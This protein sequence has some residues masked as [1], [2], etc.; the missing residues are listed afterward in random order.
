MYKMKRILKRAIAC[1]LA[2][3][4]LAGEAP[5]QKVLAAEVESQTEQQENVTKE[6]EQQ[7]AVQQAETEQEQQD[8]TDVQL[9]T[10]QPE[11]ANDVQL[12]TEQPE[13]ANDVQ[14]G[15]G[16][17]EETTGIQVEVP[18]LNY[19]Y[20]DKNRVEIGDTQNIVLSVG[21]DTTVIESAKLYVQNK[22]GEQYTLEASEIDGNA[23]LFAENYQDENQTGVYTL[24]SY[25]I[26]VDGIVYTQVL[27]ETGVDVSYGVNCDV[28]STPDAQLVDEDTVE[29]DMD[30]VS[31]DEDGNQTSEDSIA[32]AIENQQ[33]EQSEDGITRS[34]Y[35]SNGN[36]VV[37]LDPGH[38]GSDSGASGNGLREK[39][40]TLKIAQ[41]AKQE[42][43]KYAGVTVYLTRTSDGYV[44]LKDRATYAKSVNADIFV[45]LHINSNKSTSPNGA[46]IY[47][48]NRNY[49]ASFSDIGNGLATKIISKLTALGLNTWRS[50]VGGIIRED[51]CKDPDEEYMYP[52]GSHGDYHSVIRNCKK[53]GIPAILVEHAFISNASDASNYLSSDEKLKKL[54]VADAQGIAE[55]YNLKQG[56]QINGINFQD[57]NN[58]VEISA[59]CSDTKGVQYRYLYYDFA[60]QCWGV[61]SEWTTESKVEWQP[62]AGNYWVQ[63]AAVDSNGNGTTKTVSYTANKNYTGYY[64]NLN[65]MCY[66]MRD[67][68]I[69][70]GVAYDSNAS[71][72]K[73]KWQAYNLDKQEWSLVADWTG[74]N[75]V[76]WKPE[77]GNFWLYVEAMTPDGE[78]KNTIMC[79]ASQKDYS[80]HSLNL[81]GM[82]Y[83]IYD[84][85]I[86]VGIAYDSDDSNVTF[87]WEAYNLDKQEWNLVADW[88]G[89]N[90]VSWYPDKGNYWMHV[91]ART[92]DGV[93][94]EYTICFNAA[95][96]YNHKYITI[97]GIC[98]VNDKAAINLGVS[99]NTNDSSPA[100][101]W[102]IYDLS[103][104]TWSTLTD[105]TGSNWVSWYPGSG[106]YWVY[107]EARTS[108]GTVESHCIAYQVTARYEIMG[109][110]S[111]NISQMVAYYNANNAYPEFYASSDAPTIEA[112]CQ[113]YL[114]ECQAEGLKA[115]VA[116]CQA[117]LETGFL[118]YGG[119]VQINQYNFAG[120]GATGNG[121]PGNSFGSVREGVRAQVQHLKAYASTAELNNP[122]VDS[123]F[124][125][126]E[127]GTAPYVEWLGQKENPYRKGWATAKNYGYNIVNLYIA[128]LFKY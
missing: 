70:V 58:S 81:N 127:R 39:D 25:E 111:T 68:G 22:D 106:N 16:Q 77:Q 80:H 99:Y 20:V 52:D 96:N 74:S 21:D 66:I 91:T 34:T 51:E 69:D 57:K 119:D 32:S 72:V 33:Q 100:F 30:V 38:G 113:I 8:K 36:I 90:W 98:S 76:T 50:D 120:L 89:S 61:I 82:C 84:D 75:W 108:D 115:E 67:K 102:Q 42:L 116:F 29:S 124:N 104:S 123:R 35:G 5:M 3:L 94:K 71:D 46:G 117:M 128:K 110:T 43:E 19:V 64:L 63:V 92:S 56:F 105:W 4:M 54:G 17:P 101:R 78:T 95:R 62:K 112:F 6:T 65:G 87:K 26:T 59:Q 103:T 49:N 83:N 7:T 107:V 55:Y 31:F 109:T 41:Y 125:F 24:Y 9:D 48:P 121:A 40:L 126:V 114:E 60:T 27:S 122:Q 14:V 10:E 85:R 13:D 44:G 18:L 37:V 47:Y 11:D 93:T 118:R 2:V 12:D 53:E 97:N 28:E 15:T 73:F 86:D 88:T 23:I 79:F 45:S 1:L